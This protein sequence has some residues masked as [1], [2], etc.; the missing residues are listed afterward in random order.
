MEQLR[1]HTFKIILI[2]YFFDLLKK[3]TPYKESNVNDY[4]FYSIR[5]L[6]KY[7]VKHDISMVDFI[8]YVHQEFYFI[9]D[10][11]F[12]TYSLKICQQKGRF[13]N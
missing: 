9:M 5:S 7:L 6:C 2:I 8:K 11:S 1:N 12:L 4:E 10:I 13:C 3:L